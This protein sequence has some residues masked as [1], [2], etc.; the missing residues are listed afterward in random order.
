MSVFVANNAGTVRFNSGTTTIN[1][2]GTFFK[3]YRA[4]SVISIPGVGSMQLASDPTS[5]TVATG[6]VAWGAATTTFRSFEYLPRNE[7]GVLT[8][9]LAQLLNQLSNGNI[10]A[11]IDLAFSANKLPYANG[12]GTLALTDFTALARNLLNDATA[13][14]MWTTLGIPTISSFAATLLDDGTAAS[15]RNTLEIPGLLASYGMGQT[16]GAAEVTDL[17]NIPAAGAYTFTN[18]AA[19]RPSD[20]TAGVVIQ[21]HRAATTKAQIIISTTSDSTAYIRRQST[22]TW[23]PFVPIAPIVITNSNGIA[24]RLASGLQICISTTPFS[25]DANTTTGMGSGGM[26]RGTVT[27]TY[28]APFASGSTTQAMSIAGTTARWGGAATAVGATSCV[29][30]HF[31]STASATT[32]NLYG[33]A[34]GQYTL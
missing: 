2:T 20:V 15:M 13:G 3:N 8:D 29:L 1:G 4:G 34:I 27:W 7:E 14:E 9:K 32:T 5:D 31:A 25:V 21:V 26:G 33:I 12:S 11:L 18:T 24:W 28:P 10:Q 17:N 23:G 22:G 19:N 30:Y 16:T 6:V